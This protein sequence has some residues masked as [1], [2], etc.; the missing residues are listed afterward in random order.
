LKLTKYTEQTN[1]TRC[2]LEWVLRHAEINGNEKADK[3]AQQV[4]TKRPRIIPHIQKRVLKLAIVDMI[5]QSTK[6]QWKQEWTNG[7]G[8]AS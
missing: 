6:W 3:A 2:T 4:G 8:T 5:H 7:R 1:H